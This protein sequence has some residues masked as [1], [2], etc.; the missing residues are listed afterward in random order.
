MNCTSRLP[1]WDF[2]GGSAQR[3]SFQ[4]AMESGQEYDM[5]N[6]TVWCSV[7]EYVNGG[8]PVI[9]RGFPLYASEHGNFCVTTITLNSDETKFLHG[10]YLYQLTV[11]DGYG[12]I[13][14]ASCR[15][16]V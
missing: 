8:E 2:V 11:K 6:G 1:D 9:S 7:C 15:E 5:Q 10:C 14:R 3:R 12:K 4:F 13:G 16:R